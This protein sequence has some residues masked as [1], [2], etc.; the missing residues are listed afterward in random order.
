MFLPLESV[1]SYRSPLR[2]GGVSLWASLKL[3]LQLKAMETQVVS[4]EL[5]P[6]FPTQDQNCAASRITLLQTWSSPL[7]K[8]LEGEDDAGAIKLTFSGFPSAHPCFLVLTICYP[9]K[10]TK[11][12][13]FGLKSTSQIQRFIQW[14]VAQSLV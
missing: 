14:N 1:G 2:A 6:Q 4:Q 12:K 8:V 11:Y 9:N 10:D 7:F 3:R 13:R 5:V